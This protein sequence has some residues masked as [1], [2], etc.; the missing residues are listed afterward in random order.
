MAESTEPRLRALVSAV[1]FYIVTTANPD[2]YVYSWTG[3]I[4]RMLRKSEA[5][6][7]IWS[8]SLFRRDNSCP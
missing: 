7:I 1:T 5:I 3:P 2:G 4:N 6:V 8:P